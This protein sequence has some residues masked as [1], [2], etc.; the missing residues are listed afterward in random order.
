MRFYGTI[1]KCY[2]YFK[3]SPSCTSGFSTL[4]AERT[5]AALQICGRTNG[6]DVPEFRSARAKA[7]AVSASFLPLSVSRSLANGL[8]CGVPRPH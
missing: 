5:S 7:D 2:S 3:I 6:T 8:I 1:L 4:I